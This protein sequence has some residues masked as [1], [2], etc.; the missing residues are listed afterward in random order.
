MNR[1]EEILSTVQSIVS[2]PAAALDA[3]RLLQ[4]PDAEL[5]NIVRVVEY[6]PGLTSNILRLANSAYYGG[7]GVI[8]SVRN[9]IVR[10][11]TKNILQLIVAATVAPLVA[12]AVK[13]YDLPPGELWRHSIAVAVGTERIA[14]ALE[15][16]PP[17]H[18]F[19]AALLHDVG[20]LA[21]GTFVEVDASAIIAL[22]EEERISF[23][24]AEQTVLG[25]DHAEAGAILLETWKLPES[26][27][28]AIRRHHNPEGFPGDDTR[29][30]DLVHASDS[31]CLM[32]GIGAG[33][34]GL[35]YRPS[36]EVVSRLSLTTQAM[37]IAACG[38]LDGL[39]ELGGLFA[40]DNENDH[41][42]TQQT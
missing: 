18:T 26:I 6:D 27:T 20:K 3:I 14:D 19:T 33:S 2:M 39:R 25:I 30:V 35:N 10:L 42:R 4:D 16:K 1:R 23:E 7:T 15:L 13:G 9:A 32:S 36:A 22:A 8:D 34:D 5:E 37:E 38:I 41:E 29:A 24:V 17:D 28:E 21:L 31:L 11:G 12:P 40:A